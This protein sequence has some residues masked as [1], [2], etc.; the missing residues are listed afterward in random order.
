MDETEKKISEEQEALPTDGTVESAAITEVQPLPEWKVSGLFSDHMVLQR[1]VPI[2]VY[3]WSTHSGSPVTGTW[4]GETAEGVVDADGNFRL[5]F[6]PHAVSFTPTVMHIDSPCGSAVFEDILVGDVWLLGGQS[7]GEMALSSCIQ[8]TPEVEKAIS[9]DDPFRLFKQKQAVAAAHTEFHNT[10]SRDIIDPD[11]CWKRPDRDAALEFSA[12]GYYFAKLL[13]Q[14]LDAPVGIV[15]ACPGGACLRELMPAE[16]AHRRG[17]TTGANVP[18]AGYYNTLLHPLEG[19]QFRGQLFFQGESEGIW[20]E[21]A[22]SYDAD[23]AEFVADERQRFGI[24]FPFYNMQISSY[25]QEGAEFFPHLH[26]VRSRQF[27]AARLIPDYHL[28]VSRDLGALPEY[29]DWA[30]S[31]RKYEVGARLAAQVLANE[32]GIGD[33]AA[34]ES[35]TPVSVTPTDGGLTVRFDFVNGGLTA[36]AGGSVK[37]FSLASADEVLQT[38]DARITGPDTVLV[39]LPEETGGATQLGY[40][41]HPIAYLADADLCGGTGLPAPAFL[42]PLPDPAADA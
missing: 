38:L 35:P 18:V 20:K 4:D 13:T 15:M 26:W 30:H 7:N 6:A 1:D 40:A 34:A 5:T 16:L 2:T 27:A 12:M 17:Y 3:G 39:T 24:D 25:R 31:L 36:G 19:M 11:W 14:Q 42:L 32:Y 23:L 9:G 29:K 22:L 28:S 41:M 33:P 8:T 21:M 37:G 10:P